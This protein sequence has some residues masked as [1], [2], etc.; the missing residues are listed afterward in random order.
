MDRGKERMV[1][2][3]CPHPGHQP[4]SICFEDFALVYSGKVFKAQ[5]LS[6]KSLD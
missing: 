2:H 4:Q 6:I 1:V 5:G 3:S